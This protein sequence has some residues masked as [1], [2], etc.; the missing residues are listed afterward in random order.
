[1]IGFRIMNAL[2]VLD[3]NLSKISVCSPRLFSLKK[4]F[5]FLLSRVIVVGGWRWRSGWCGRYLR[6]PK[7]SLGVQHISQFLL[8]NISQQLFIFGRFDDV[9]DMFMTGNFR[10]KIQS[11]VCWYVFS[12]VN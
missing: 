6:Q 4:M 10:W 12:N 7:T 5:K 9:R 3:V 2:K 11:Y 8:F 1:M